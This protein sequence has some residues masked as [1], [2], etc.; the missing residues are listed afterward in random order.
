MVACLQG[1][2]VRLVEQ[3]LGDQALHN[4]V[5]NDKAEAII[6]V[7]SIDNVANDKFTIS[8]KLSHG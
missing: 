6:G 8:N 2:G 3:L 5:V 1:V 4:D 7:L